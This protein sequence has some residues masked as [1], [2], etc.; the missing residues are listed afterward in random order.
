MVFGHKLII[1]VNPPCKILGILISA[2]SLQNLVLFCAI[3]KR[4]KNQM[5]LVLA[6]LMNWLKFLSKEHVSI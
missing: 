3:K 5:G 2:N 6:V 1:Y 4:I